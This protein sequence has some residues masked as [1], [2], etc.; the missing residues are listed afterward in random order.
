MHIYRYEENP[1]IIRWKRQCLGKGAEH[2]LLCPAPFR[3][4]ASASFACFRRPFRCHRPDEKVSRA[5]AG[6]GFGFA[7]E[8]IP[9]VSGQSFACGFFGERLQLFWR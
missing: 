9:N 4:F 8:K 7:N 3:M 2:L 5:L 6:G 1:L